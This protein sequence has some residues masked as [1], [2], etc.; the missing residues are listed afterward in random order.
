MILPEHHVS[1]QE[2]I[3]CVIYSGTLDKQGVLYVRH[4]KV[5]FITLPNKYYV[6]TKMCSQEMQTHKHKHT[7]TPTHHT[8]PQAQPTPH[9]HTHTHTHT[10]VLNKIILANTAP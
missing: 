6:Q 3:S 9:T 5:S 7:H 10:H 1:V 4:V 2:Y 8:P